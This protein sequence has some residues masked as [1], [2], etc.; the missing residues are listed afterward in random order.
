M[1]TASASK[2]TS[3]EAKNAL[4]RSGYLLENRIAEIFRKRGCYVEPNDIYP[5]TET[6][7]AREYDI[8]A[9]TAQKAGPNDHDFLFPIFI[10]ECVN[11][12]QPIA[13]MTK[14]PQVGFL[15]HQEVKI[16]GLPTKIE[17]TNG[18]IRLSQFL[19][20]EQFH[21]YCS[22]R[23]ATQYCSFQKKKGS[24]NEWMA[25]H[26]DIHFG[27]LKT[28]CDVVEHKIETHFNN[29]IF[30]ADKKEDLNIQMYYP[31]L[32]TQGDLIEVEIKPRSIR[33]TKANHLQCRRSILKRGEQINYQIDVVTERFISRFIDLSEGEIAKTARLL[34]ERHE[35]VREAIDF[36]TDAA[37][38]AKSPDEIRREMQF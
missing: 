24:Q 1:P 36:I 11:N 5:D 33:T 32:V 25:F 38:K 28:L 18:W 30:E 13:F 15:H 37:L 12:P 7:K 17:S 3:A 6:G 16:S 31:V 27:A 21:H 20:I 19:E 23:I 4:L 22:G 35:K 9:M 34:H 10:V 26:D 8:F 2:I 29:W 14:E